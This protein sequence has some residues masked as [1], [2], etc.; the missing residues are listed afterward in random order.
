MIRAIDSVAKRLGNTRAV[1]PQYYVHPARA[2]IPAGTHAPLASA[3]LPIGRA[4]N[5]HRRPQAATRSRCLQFLQED[6][7]ET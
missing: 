1:L 7:A 5:I 2:G 3:A 4:G 6:A